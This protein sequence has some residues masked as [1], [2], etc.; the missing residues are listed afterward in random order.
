ME[1][2]L[3][4]A[5]E[6]FFYD[7]I[8]AISN[9]IL[10]LLIIRAFCHLLDIRSKPLFSALMLATL[11]FG[12]FERLVD[13]SYDIHVSIF[14]PLSL[15]FL[16]ITLSKG[17]L[18]PRIT[19]TFLVASATLASEGLAVAFCNLVG[20]EIL[21]TIAFGSDEVIQSN[22]IVAYISALIFAMVLLEILIFIFDEVLDV[23]LSTP[24]LALLLSSYLLSGAL[25]RR[26]HAVMITTLTFRTA[27]LLTTLLTLALCITLVYLTRKDVLANMESANRMARM[28][29]ARHV[30]TEVEG[31]AQRSS[32]VR[33]LRHDLA[34]QIEVVEQLA[35]QGQTQ[36][37][38]GYLETLIEQARTVSGDAE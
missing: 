38:D 4:R 14:G 13:L 29:Q 8:P 7:P 21:P 1:D 25:F 19:K 9:I 20:V 28:R 32:D 11:G 10:Q 33:C 26:A 30:C 37:A 18:G 16:P 6:V 22:M 23:T 17:P 24:A 35:H 15:L 27:T 12:F 5:H 34:N 31:I 3:S 2:L 36:E